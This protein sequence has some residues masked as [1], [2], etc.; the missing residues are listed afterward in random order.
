MADLRPGQG[1]GFCVSACELPH[2]Q[3]A[4]LPLTSLNGK[5]EWVMN[6][7]E[8]MALIVLFTLITSCYGFL[9][10]E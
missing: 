5:R 6:T 7:S 10:P 8:A 3:R 1:A 4:A 9:A 2:T